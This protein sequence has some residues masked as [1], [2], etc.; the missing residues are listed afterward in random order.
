[1]NGGANPMR[2][3][4]TLFILAPLLEKPYFTSREA[5]KM[6]AHSAVLSHYVKTGHL[7]RI[8]RGVYQRT[9]YQNPATFRWEDLVKA[10]SSVKDGVVCLISALAIYDLTDEIPRQHWIAI[11]HDTSVKANREVRIVRYRD[12]ELGKTKIELEGTLV[13]IFDR[14]RTIVDAFR[15]LSREIAIKAL[16]AAL[17]RGGKNRIDLIKLQEYARRLQCT[18]GPY[19]MS[20]TT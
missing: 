15:M 17:T 16:K 5:R 6:G 4:K 2:P 10:V 18:I 1:M 9:N 12:I 7:K 13:P 14:E 20:M 11:R 3:Q 8:Q 19:L